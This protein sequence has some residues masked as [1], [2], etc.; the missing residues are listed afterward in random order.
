MTPIV[1]LVVVETLRR[2]QLHPELRPHPEDREDY[3]HDGHE[4]SQLDLVPEH[5]TKQWVFK[6]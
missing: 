2:W 3:A 6:L 5:N 1:H 4:E